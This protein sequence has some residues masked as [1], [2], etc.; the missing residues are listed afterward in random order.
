[1]TAAVWK[2]LWLSCCAKTFPRNIAW[3][4]HRDYNNI[5]SFCNNI[6]VSIL[7]HTTMGHLQRFNN[8]VCFRSRSPTSSK[9]TS[10]IQKTKS[11]VWTIFSNHFNYV[12]GYWLITYIQAVMNKCLTSLLIRII[13]LFGVFEIINSICRL[14]RGLTLASSVFSW[15]LLK[16]QSSCLTF[17]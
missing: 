1:M 6:F 11:N 3:G 7:H 4:K 2:L 5:S 8:V 17:N 10:L 14:K 9:E 13:W 16:M 15:F 12:S